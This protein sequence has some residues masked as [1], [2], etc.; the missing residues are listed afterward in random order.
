MFQFFFFFLTNGRP[1]NTG[2]KPLIGNQENQCVP[3]QFNAPWR[4]TTPTQNF[5]KARINE[6]W[7]GWVLRVG[8]KLKLWPPTVQRSLGPRANTE[9]AKLPSEP[10]LNR[11][12]PQYTRGVCKIC[13][14]RLFCG[15]EVV[16][17]RSWTC[18][19]D[20]VTLFS[21]LRAPVFE[22][23]FSRPREPVLGLKT[24]LS[25]NRFLDFVN[26]F[27][28]LREPVFEAWWTCFLGLK[29]LL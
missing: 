15:R 25:R 3:G 9:T 6:S 20:F 16:P 13:V 18:L 2:E 10:K 7:K 8:E 1:V 12:R 28:K 22:S 23:L 19:Q 27:S 17:R 11:D 4:N 14:F 29:T 21:R 24:P 5:G 26:L